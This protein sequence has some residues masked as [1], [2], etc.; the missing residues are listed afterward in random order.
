MSMHDSGARRAGISISG[1]SAT[2]V[3]APRLEGQEGPAQVVFTGVLIGA[4]MITR[5]VVPVG[6]RKNDYLVILGDVDAVPALAPKTQLES[7][8]PLGK[9][10]SSPVYLECRM[11]RAGIDPFTVPAERL[12]DDS[13]AVAVDPRNLLELRH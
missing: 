3:V 13:V 6:D 12:L 4:S 10:G 9:V 8:A 1:A 7:G 5:H 2:P 11:L